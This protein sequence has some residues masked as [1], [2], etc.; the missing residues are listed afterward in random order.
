MRGMVNNLEI[1]K[2]AIVVVVFLAAAFLIVSLEGSLTGFVVSEGN[3][4]EVDVEEEVVKRIDALDAIDRGEAIMDEMIENNFSIAYVNDSLLEV[5]RVFEQVK[6]A[7]ILRDSDASD[8][9]K[10]EA[11]KELRLVDWGEIGYGNVIEIIDSIEERRDEAFGVYDFL[12]ASRMKAEN[13]GEKID[14]S[15]INSLL[16]EAGIAFYEGRYE[17]SKELLGKVDDL[18]EIKRS[19]SATLSV[20]RR[21][22][23]GFVVRYWYYI[24]LV[25]ILLGVGGF[26]SYKKISLKALRARIKKMK[27]ERKVLLGLMK[28]VQKARF[29]ENKISGLVYRIRMGKFE[30]R[31]NVIKERLPVLEG[32]LR[33][34]ERRK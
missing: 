1:S 9:A 4:S 8:Y 13:Y 26:F 32:R 2:E 29:K 7:E 20:L 10:I 18:F 24:L 14:V 21:G 31:M 22:A 17:E 30:E 12:V 11:R 27:V 15:Q 25:L 5:R 19:E 23:M 6:Y 28:S 33:K 34:M 3:V 16:D